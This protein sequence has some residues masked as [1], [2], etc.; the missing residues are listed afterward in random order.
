LKFEGELKPIRNEADY[1]RAIT[2]LDRLW[3]AKS[4]TPDGD[5]LDVLATLVETY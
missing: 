2:E 3:G 5:R 4:G 1:R